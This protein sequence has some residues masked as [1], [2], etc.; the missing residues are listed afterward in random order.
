MTR[1]K[2][3]HLAAY[4]PPTQVS[5]QEVEERVNRHRQVLPDGCL[6]RL[7]GVQFRRYAGPGVQ[8]SDLAVEAARKILCHQELDSIDCLIFAA[9]SSDLIE[10]ATANIVQAKLGLSCPV[11]DI[12]NACNSFVTAMQV[13]SSLI[14]SGQFRRVLITSGEILHQAI[15][16]EIKDPAELPNRLAGF[17][18]GD[19]GAAALLEAS[20]DETGF[21]YQT[22]KS[23][24][25]HW[26]LCTIPGGGSMF[27]HD[28]KKMY[29]EGQTTELRNVFI[30]EQGAMVAECFATSGWLAQ[31]IDHVFTHQ[32]SRSS[33][34]L[35]AHHI[36]IPVDRFY[37]IVSQYG[38]TA[39]ASIPLSMYLAEQE[40]VLKRGQKV[41]IV[42]LASG[43]SISLQLVIW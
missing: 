17:S 2:I 25:H 24:G 4:A 28:P 21:V 10:P 15:Q 12:K 36:G 13:G 39:S 19:A 32:V 30:R 27:P 38:N 43:I 22:M 41:M 40:G 35:I 6:E 9:A 26:E 14:S 7:F 8:C 18:L 42:G 20:S 16:F 11:F 1:I 33:F 5:S 31:D 23:L 3:S 34:D 29:F 37:R